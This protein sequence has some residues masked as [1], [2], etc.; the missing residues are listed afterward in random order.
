MDFVNKLTGSGNNSG[1]SAGESL[2]E[3]QSGGGGGGGGGFM[4]KMNDMAGGGAQ[5]EKDEDFLDKGVDFVQENFLG[6]GDQSNESAAEQAKDEMISDA[7]RE[8]YKDATGSDFPIK[9][10]DKK[11]G[12]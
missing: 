2:S 11:Y 9:D 6:Q 12:V 4:G 5:G 8:R 7:I 1:N 3:Q 10:K